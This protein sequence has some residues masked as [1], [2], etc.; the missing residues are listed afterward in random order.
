MLYFEYQLIWHNLA[1]Y[2]KVKYQIISVN[3]FCILYKTYN[4]YK[5]KLNF[6]A[7]NQDQIY[8]YTNYIIKHFLLK[9]P[10]K[11]LYNVF[12]QILYFKYKIIYIY[13]Y[14]YKSRCYAWSL[15]SWYLDFIKYSLFAWI[16]SWRLN[17]C[18]TVKILKSLS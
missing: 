13:I 15:L 10:N 5:K 4:K 8:T 12:C 11:C 17:F 18:K 2:V 6:L 9:L 7:N 16:Y 1:K 3:I 14:I